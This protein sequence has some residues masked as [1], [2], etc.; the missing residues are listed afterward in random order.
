MKKLCIVLIVLSLLFSLGTGCFAAQAGGSC[1]SST[2]WSFQNGVLTVSG[3]GG[4][5][6]FTPGTQPWAAFRDSIT[7]VVVESGVDAIGRD[8]F[9]DLPRLSSVRLP[10]TLWSID[11]GAFASC[12][13]LT[14]IV[15]PEGLTDLGGYVFSNSGL[16]AVTIP[17][18]LKNLAFASFSQCTAL[19]SVSF[20]GVPRRISGEAFAGCTALTSIVIPESVENLDFAF[21][22]CTALTSITL[23]KSLKS[24]RSTFSGCTA[25][26]TVVLPEGLTQL[27]STFSGCTALTNVNIPTTVTKLDG[28]FYGCTALQNITIPDTVTAIGSNTFYQTGLAKAALP[29]GL[30]TISRASFSNCYSL[31]EITLPHGVT[32]VENNAF[33]SC[34]NL[35]T[36]TI[37]DTVK[38]IG[39]KAFFCR[40]SVKDVYYGGSEAQWKAITVGKDNESLLKATIHYNA[41][42][43]KPIPKTGTAFASTQTV[44]VDGKPVTLQA[45]ALKDAKGNPTNYVKLR[46][47][48]WILNGSGAQF[49]VGWDG[50]V[51]ILTCT[52]YTPNGS[53][54]STPF[55]GNRNYTVPSA[56]T[57]IDGRKASLTAISLTDDRGGGYTYYQLRDLG[58]AL[59]FNVGWSAQQG[60]FIQT[61]RPYSDAD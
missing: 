15:L 58:R 60:I 23:P 16:T 19:K 20:A 44:L 21:K 1:G 42:I 36:V 7:T 17:A 47:V 35:K 28:T 59:G 9:C 29:Q 45:Y 2:S 3:S 39:D 26:K 51:N 10:G 13:A 40:M 52:P 25:L 31:T 57:N 41:P 11:S 55:S 48:A 4:M 38:T 53:E 8:A 6:D 5:G 46:D 18:S 50:S 30:T 43:A 22:N 37:P 34:Y 27:N 49:N 24:V 14:S 56:A 32:A 12:P 61:D 54:M 33:S